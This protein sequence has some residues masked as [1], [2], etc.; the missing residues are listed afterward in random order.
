[1]SSTPQ[2]LHLQ[3]RFTLA[4]GTDSSD[5]GTA[6]AAA[7]GAGVGEFGGAHWFAAQSAEVVA[8]PAVESAAGV[9]GTTSSDPGATTAAAS[10]CARIPV[11]VD[12]WLTPSGCLLSSW[13]LDASSA[14]PAKLAPGLKASLPRV[15]LVLGVP[16]DLDQVTWLGRG[17]E[18]CYPDRKPSTL[19]GRYTR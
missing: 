11:A 2:L 16:E 6:A 10:P 15:G 19:L 9:T 14:L 17:P 7:G 5:P 13:Q 3:A 12:Y 4:P 8:T 1:V 18:E